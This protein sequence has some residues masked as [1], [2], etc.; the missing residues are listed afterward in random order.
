M[1]IVKACTARA[2]CD[3][4]SPGAP[5]QEG[6]AHTFL[7]GPEVPGGRA[8]VC[9]RPRPPQLGDPAGPGGA[10][11]GPWLGMGSG[12]QVGA[13]LRYLG[14]PHFL[15]STTDMIPR[16][17]SAAVTCLICGL[18]LLLCVW[19]GCAKHEVESLWCKPNFSADDFIPRW[20][21]EDERWGHTAGYTKVRASTED[22]KFFGFC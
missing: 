19:K 17:V 3:G 5:P 10:G 8:G 22:V 14:V 9:K 13:L 21:W 12:A 18:F 15:F 2:P 7:P 6:Y 16:H 11:A 20:R 4:H 1:Q